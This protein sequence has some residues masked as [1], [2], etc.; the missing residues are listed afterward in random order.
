MLPEIPAFSPLSSF[1]TTVPFGT[2]KATIRMIGTQIRNTRYPRFYPAIAVN[3]P[4]PFAMIV[5]PILTKIDW[6]PITLDFSIP[7]K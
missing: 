4:D 6:N 1:C 7:V 3:I 2:V 5:P